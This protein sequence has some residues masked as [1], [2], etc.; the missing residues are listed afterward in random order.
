MSVKGYIDL[1]EITNSG[2]VLR[3]GL[4]SRSGI[5]M[6]PEAATKIKKHFK[7][8]DEYMKYMHRSIKAMHIKT[9]HFHLNLTCRVTP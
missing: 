5:S 4:A 2:Q 3:S 8:L 7:F 9:A 1:I 6:A